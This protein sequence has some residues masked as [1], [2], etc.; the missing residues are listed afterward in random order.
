M[1]GRENKCPGCSFGKAG[2]DF[3]WKMRDFMQAMGRFLLA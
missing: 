1:S 2:A 3:F